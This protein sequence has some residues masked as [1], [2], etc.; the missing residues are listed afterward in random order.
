MMGAQLIHSVVM[1]VH[2][3][4][5]NDDKRFVENQCFVYRHSKVI[6]GDQSAVKRNIQLCHNVNN[7]FIHV[8][9]FHQPLIVSHTDNHVDRNCRS[10]VKNTVLPYYQ[11]SPG[12]NYRQ[13]KFK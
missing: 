4:V 1:L 13:M 2:A 11:L 3:L 6:K 12:T 10:F 7:Q 9:R 5:N 8:N